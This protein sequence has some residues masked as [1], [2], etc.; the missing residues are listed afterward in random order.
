M[1][2]IKT[3]YCTKLNFPKRLSLAALFW[4]WEAHIKQNYSCSTNK[5]FL[6]GFILKSTESASLLLKNST[7]DFQNS[8]GFEKSACFV[9]TF[10]RNFECL[11]YFNLT[12]NFLKNEKLFQKNCSTIE[13]ALFPY[14]TALSEASVK[15]YNG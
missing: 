6:R 2:V 13:D 5:L 14:K 12:T 7:R 4:N 1:F 15:T 9:V 3:G 11:H 10:T 8:P